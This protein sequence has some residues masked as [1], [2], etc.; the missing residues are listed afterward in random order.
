VQ[1]KQSAIG[2]NTTRLL[3]LLVCGIAIGNVFGSDVVSQPLRAD[4]PSQPPPTVQAFSQAKTCFVQTAQASVRC[5][6]GSQFYATTTLKLGASVDVYVETSDGWSGIRPPEGSHNWIPA[7]SVY[8]LPGG[9]S[10]EV[11]VEKTAAFIGSDTPDIDS[12][13]FQTMLVQTQ[14]VAILDEAYR[15]ED[16]KKSLWFRIAPPQGEFR[17]IKTSQLGTNPVQLAASTKNTPKQRG[18]TK[19]ANE[20][21]PA[22]AKQVKETTPETNNSKVVKANQIIQREMVQGEFVEGNIVEGEII[23]GDVEGSVDGNIVWSDEAEQIARIEREIEI[24]QAQIAEEQGIESDAMPAPFHRKKGSHVTA[25]GQDTAY[26]NTLN[27]PHGQPLRV[28]P[29]SGVLGWLGFSIVDDGT[30]SMQPTPMHPTPTH[31]PGGGALSRRGPYA[32][33]S[34][35][36]ENRL[37]RLPRPTRRYSDG[38][39]LSIANS[40]GPLFGSDTQTDPQP[41]GDTFSSEPSRAFE[42]VPIA[43]V[44]YRRDSYLEPRAM[45][46]TP[47]HFS[48]PAIQDAL[49]Q[50]TAMVSK[51]TEQWNLEPYRVSAK[52]WI[53]LGDSPL[54][55]GEARLLLDRIEEFESLRTRSIA[56]QSPAQAPPLQAAP[57]LQP[58]PP[59]NAPPM[60]EAIPPRVAGS[61]SEASGWLV[62]VHTSLPGQPEFALTDDAGKVLAYVRPTTGLNLRRYVQQPVTV[63]GAPGYIPNLAARQI[64]AERVVRLR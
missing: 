51:P 57:P 5:G 40:Q 36:I 39:W 12:L 44:N 60:T 33:H 16:E 32:P 10:G 34:P 18:D 52:S 15:E 45:T 9:K 38:S 1:T 37:D 17:W 41:E 6:P 20:V 56:L 46:E 62:S 50:L 48:T 14:K 47:D 13:L 53:E 19:D 3:R 25:Y 31:R 21:Q 11:S 2:K 42:N 55:R 27:G 23:D 49:L 8:L 30:T 29:V 35:I 26:W 63:Y 54:V 61:G 4:E 64:V 43:A 58:A 28:G 24:E 22:S 7:S 59:L